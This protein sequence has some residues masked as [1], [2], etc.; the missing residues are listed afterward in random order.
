MFQH[1]A[2]LFRDEYLWTFR[3]LDDIID[4]A[5]HLASTILHVDHQK[6]TTK[7]LEFFFAILSKCYFYF[8]FIVEAWSPC[9]ARC[10][11]GMRFR[12]VECK[13]FMEFS[14]TVATLPDKVNKKTGKQ[15][16][17]TSVSSSDQSYL[18]FNL[19]L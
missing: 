9:S 12:R 4:K 2:F 1:Y 16:L 11:E 18:Q 3:T 13:I 14:K 8:S 10:G 15:V 19:T 6:S 5:F 7:S 17:I